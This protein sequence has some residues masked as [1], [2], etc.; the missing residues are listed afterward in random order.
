[1]SNFT[2][3]QYSNGGWRWTYTVG[4]IV[5]VIVFLIQLYSV[6]FKQNKNKGKPAPNNGTEMKHRS[7]LQLDDEE[8][9]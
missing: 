5:L 8:E 7:S 2:P 4:F 6:M 9:E 1:M 3:V